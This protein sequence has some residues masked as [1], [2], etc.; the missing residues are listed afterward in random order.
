MC[1]V[2]CYTTLY[3]R[4]SPVVRPAELSSQRWC[5]AQTGQTLV[6][7][8]LVCDFSGFNVAACCDK[9]LDEWKL[10]KFCSNE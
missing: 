7:S 4:E 9:H 1:G 5:V 2:M 8:L 10:L 3:W 6:I